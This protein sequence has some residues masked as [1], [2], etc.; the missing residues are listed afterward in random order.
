MS[1]NV[2]VD[3]IIMQQNQA[4]KHSEFLS[5]MSSSRNALALGGRSRAKLSIIHIAIKY[6]DNR[7]YE[8]VLMVANNFK[9]PS[10]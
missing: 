6:L 2:T 3:V 10:Y 7:G 5:K 8:N 9:L 4:Y 1:L